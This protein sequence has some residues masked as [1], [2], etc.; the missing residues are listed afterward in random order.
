MARREG[1]R[2]D[3]WKETQREPH[4]GED[5]RPPV[6]RRAVHPGALLAVEEEAVLENSGNVLLVAKR[7]EHEREEDEAHPLRDAPDAQPPPEGAIEDPDHDVPGHGLDDAG[8]VLPRR[9]QLQRSCK[10]E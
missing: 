6:R 3:R 5:D 10:H 7:H 8:A 9:R 4:L 2:S 1:H